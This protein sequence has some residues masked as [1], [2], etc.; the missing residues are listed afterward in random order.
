M[1]VYKLD[2]STAANQSALETFHPCTRDWFLQAFQKPT[3][4]QAQAWPEIA[5]GNSTLLLAPTGSGKTLAAF[6]AAI[7]RLFFDGQSAATA[8]RLAAEAKAKAKRS[9][10]IPKLSTGIRVLYISPLKALGV[11][12]DRNL[13]G[14]L[15]GLRA[16][17]EKHEVKHWLPRVAVRSGDTSQKERSQI[18][19]DP[20]DIL[21]TT[22]ESLYLMLT[23]KSDVIL[24]TVD[25]III[26]EIHALAGT[27]RG[28]H[29]M[30]TLERLERLR[31][32][33]ESD[34]DGGRE[35]GLLESDKRKGGSKT[36][37]GS[38]RKPLQRIGLSATQRPL[39][40]IATLLG[41]GNASADPSVPVKPRPVTI[42][43]ASERRRFDLT[44]ETPAEDR[45]DNVA[46]G[47]NPFGS[48]SA[49]DDHWPG[50]S[51]DDDPMYQ[52]GDEDIPIGNASSAP[53]IP[54]VWPSIH[55]RLVELIRANRSTMIFVNS[56]RL[57]E[58]L[59]TAINEVAEE[60]I[61]LAHH[62]SIAK[63]IRSEIEDRLKRGN[64]PAMVATS[65]ME[66]GI[67]MGAVDLVIQIE[68]PPSIASATQRIGRA[69]HQVGAISTGIIFPKYK[70]D[71]V[72]CTA[73][74]GAMLKGWVEE[75]HYPRNP[76]DV[77]AQQIVAMT[78]RQSIHIDELFST[79]R[80]AAPF[81]D[82]PYSSFVG[83]M[84]L[85]SGRY[86]SDEF[87]ELRPRVN[88]DRI[89][90]IV[91]PRKGAQRL[92]ILNAGTIPDRGLYGV[93]LV[94]ENGESGGRVGE[95]DE[96]MVFECRPGD[97]FLLG[98]SSW[99]VMDITRD[100]VEVVPAPGEP[101]RM[102]FWRGD[103]PGRP[104]E[105]GRAI[106][107]LSRELVSMPP[108]KATDRLISEHG[109]QESAAE[110]LL[111]YLEDQRA[112][113]VELPTDQCLVI[114][115]F[116]DEVGDWRI[117]ILSPFGSRVHAPWAMLVSSRMRRDL[118]TEVD[119]MW[120]DD[121]IVL[122][123]PE[124]HDVPDAEAFFPD[125]DEVEDELVREVGGTA[126]FAA[127][128]RENAARSLL[129][130]RRNPTRRTPLWLQRKRS[131][132]LL[133]VA[134][135]FHDF[136]MLMETYRECLR[137][138][139][140]M[141]GFISL[142]KDV[143]SRTIRVHQVRSEYPSPFAG[144]VLFNYVGNFIYDGDAPLAER[145][146]QTLALDHAQLRELLG[147]VDLR[148]MFDAD[149]LLQLNQ[150]L[151]KLTDWKLRHADD[152]HG[153]LLDLGRL[154]RSEIHL[155]CHDH[156]V[157]SGD[158][159]SWLKELLQH[160][161]AFQYQANEEVCF[162]ASEDAGKLRDALGIMPP[163]GL[164]DAFLEPVQEALVSLTSQYARTHGPFTSQQVATKLGLGVAPILSALSI[165]EE[166]ERVVSGEFLP[167]RH[168]QEWC[169]VNV[170]RQLKRRSLAAL[171]KEV[172]PVEPEAL[173]RFLPDWHGITRPRKGL[174]GLLDVIEQLQGAP[175][176]AS[177]LEKEI[178]PARITGYRSAD[179]D[180]LCVQGEVIWRG[181][182]STSNNDGRIGLFLTDHYATLAPFVEPVDDPVADDIRKLLASR[183]ALF[184]HQITDSVRQF[185][186][187]L[188][189]L[190]W[191]MV[192]SGELTNDTLTPLRSLRSAAATR[193]RSD[194]RSQRGFRSRR[195]NKLSGSEGRWTL[196]PKLSL[197]KASLLRTKRVDV[198]P[199][200]ADAA[201]HCQVGDSVAVPS[202]TERQ[203]AI[204]GQL[205]ERHGVLTKEMLSREEVV[206]GFSGLYPILKA[207]EEAGKV[208][209][210]YFVAGLGAAQ[211][212][213]PG[214]EDQLRRFRAVDDSEFDAK[215]LILAATDPAAPWGNALSWPESTELGRL[216]RVA[217]A[218]VMI[219]QGELIGYL[220][221]THEHL[222]TFLPVDEVHRSAVIQ[223][224]A[225]ALARLANPGR[226][227]LINKIDGK[228]PGSSEL[229]SALLD[230]GF[231]VTSKGLLHSGRLTS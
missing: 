145:R 97:V 21:I 151:Q 20:P 83:V 173:A 46:T 39:D 2:M 93:F 57:A 197:P 32:A 113:T 185:P 211:F 71:L 74:T 84:D 50:G 127:K 23:S 187:D 37:R 86:P 206:G 209:R 200:V 64:L 143:K 55:P 128:F 109:L 153:L 227:M 9:R 14:P 106:G 195:P 95:L 30:T 108:A 79:M 91:S 144:A 124:T 139:F 8:E 225:K 104:L 221:R 201:H 19:K 28:A 168:G 92:A 208:R 48:D 140:D 98:A 207:M 135:R 77:L 184:F 152:L 40:E 191:R 29:L 194:R 88:W 126:L 68:A 218:K 22:P 219:W 137:D 215:P 94:G 1:A 205:I 203:M 47:V 138:V 142:L 229:K 27:K 178:L 133:K 34:A 158:S 122:R 53:V 76:L 62:G 114:E 182:D 121:G 202:I 177:T 181:F 179:L 164:A 13:R 103:G 157:K 155:R 31:V 87:S 101:G 24:K 176:P 44:I 107:Q 131:A 7:D 36:E 17:A 5:A 73:A 3:G 45:K 189:H 231:S 212:A 199:T 123:I 134:S 150:E 214:A 4:V 12:V 220:N 81:F 6:L 141:P 51:P 117:V 10:G 16:Y 72:A 56:R 183:G 111:G 78:S 119:V 165:L 120:T 167:G 149:I 170:L 116:L 136:P 41:G 52:P 99:R 223:C 162:A 163:S 171:R 132:D 82:L 161:R 156:D 118:D 188:L 63:D 147:T 35:I 129:L 204:A 60:E 85:L 174:D 224:L 213:A 96:E 166:R 65:S 42:V 33:V 175:L 66:L 102:P 146:A 130:P 38:N 25:T 26:D 160:R 169:D 100:R 18:V 61:A 198:E 196:L 193:N 125:P 59:A 228:A 54:S 43:D 105:F 49:A 67:D 69:G 75:T 172:E 15:A 80:S 192:W 180:E 11:D 226:C 210:G 159:E 230:V 190:L 216:Q 148:E 186:N 217:D 154:T 112:A 110:S 58:R 222:T 89:T 90:G 115:S 70:G